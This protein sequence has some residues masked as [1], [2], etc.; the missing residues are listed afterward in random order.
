M[1]QVDLPRSLAQVREPG[2]GTSSKISIAATRYRGSPPQAGET[3][4]IDRA[5][6]TAWSFAALLGPPVNAAAQQAALAVLASPAAITGTTVAAV[7]ASANAE[8][9]R[10]RAAVLSFLSTL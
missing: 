9:D 7:T 5:L 3:W 6:G 4:I 8:L 1:E 2:A 10:I